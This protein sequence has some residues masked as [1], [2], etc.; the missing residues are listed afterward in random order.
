M[1]TSQEKVPLEPLDMSWPD[2]NRKRVTYLLI[3]PL[4]L[5]LWLTLPD[6]RK[7][8]SKK[9]FVI[10]FT[11]SILWIA[12]FSY[13]MVWWATIT[14]QTF[15]IPPEGYTYYEDGIC[16]IA[17]S[18]QSDYSNLYILGDTFLRNFVSTYNY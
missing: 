1:S 6:T 11:G 10:T 3:L 2:T 4:I 9:F 12:I 5:P 15:T 7:P 18:Y 14:G 17:V 13:L 8:E 16:I